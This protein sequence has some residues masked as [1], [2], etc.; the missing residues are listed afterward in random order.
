M[1]GHLDAKMVFA[2]GESH[3]SSGWIVGGGNLKLPASEKNALGFASRDGQSARPY[4]S[5]YTAI[6]LCWAFWG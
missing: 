2:P 5:R 4:V 6:S 3:F 1:R